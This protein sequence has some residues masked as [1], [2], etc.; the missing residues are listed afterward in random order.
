MFTLFK[1]FL[2]FD[3]LDAP[4]LV[5][6]KVGLDFGVWSCWSFSNFSDFWAFTKGLEVGVVSTEA[7]FCGST[8][9]V[10]LFGAFAAGDFGAFVAGDFGV[11]EAGDFGV[12]EAGNFAVL[13]ADDF[14]SVVADRDFEA[15]DPSGFVAAGDFGVLAA[16]D[17]GAFLAVGTFLTSLLFELRV[18]SGL[19]FG[20]VMGIFEDFGV[21]FDKFGG[22]VDG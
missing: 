11:F 1:D 21:N 8:F 9:S 13:G 4:L 14:G 2:G 15:A 3:L 22:F 20:V 16:G 17:F 10:M 7:I 18:A 6:A 19:D 12:F 5:K